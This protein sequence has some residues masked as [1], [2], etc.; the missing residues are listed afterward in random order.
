MKKMPVF[1]YSLLLSVKVINYSLF[2]LTLQLMAGIYIHIPFCKQACTYC[3]FHFSTLLKNKTELLE[4]LLKEIEIQQHFFPLKTVIKTIYFGGGTPSILSAAEINHILQKIYKHFPIDEQA[5]ITLEA[6]PDDLTEE[7]LYAL[8]NETSVNRLSIGIQSFFDEDLKYMNRAHNATQ[9]KMCIQLAQRSGF[10]NLSAD[11]IYGTPT[12]NNER[13][14]ENLDTL[15]DLNVPHIS[16]YALTVEEKTQL[17][18]LIK[19]KKTVAPADEQTA[20]Q[21]QILTEAM[22]EHNYLQYEI[23]NFCREP[24]FA[25]HNTN[26]WKG[27]PYLGIGPSAHSFNG[28]VRSWNIRNNAQ[29]IKKISA[30]ELPDESENLSSADKYNEYVMTN[31]RTIWGVDVKEISDRF[32]EKVQQHFL[33]EINSFTLKGQ[34]IENN[35][36]Y[37]LTN[38]GKLFCDHITAHL[39]IEKD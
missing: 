11:L 23:S 21:F 15:F 28:E 10:K 3:N 30:N 31:I 36:I 4:A 16:C 9:A 26:Y 12:M 14:K 25:E 24:Y 39:F 1:N 5:E 6:N 17:A 32:G 35:G 8:K 38:S 34:A 19:K 29:Y 18:D 22:K 33:K 27:I 2:A 37:T 13:W 20:Q 7:Y